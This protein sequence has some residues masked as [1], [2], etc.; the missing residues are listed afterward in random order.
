MATFTPE[1]NIG[2]NTVVPPDSITVGSGPV[3]LSV[4]ITVDP[5]SAAPG[6]TV[7]YT[8]TVTNPDTITDATD[9]VVT[10][11]LPGGT[12]SGHA[13]AGWT[14]RHR[15]SFGEHVDVDDPDDSQVRRGPG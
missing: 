14:G 11:A 10:D 2:N 9:V 13:A 1:S 12:D 15:G 4:A 3:D 6:D 8:V 5:T 7:T